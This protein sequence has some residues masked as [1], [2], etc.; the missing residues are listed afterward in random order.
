MYIAIPTGKLNIKPGE[1]HFVYLKQLH[2]F[3]TGKV[4]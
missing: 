2:S 3:A 4:R 1:L